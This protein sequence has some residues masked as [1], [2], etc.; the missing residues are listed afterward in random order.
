MTSANKI[1]KLTAVAL[2]P[3]RAP[4]T[5][6]TAEARLLDDATPTSFSIRYEDQI[7]IWKGF[8]TD[9]RVWTIMT[10]TTDVDLP[11]DAIGDQLWFANGG[12]GSAIFEQTFLP[13][14]NSVL[15]KVK[16]FQPSASRTGVMRQLGE[17]D[18]V[19]YTLSIDGEPVY[20]RATT[21]FVAS[22][23]ANAFVD[24]RTVNFSSDVP[25]EW[26][27]LM[28]AVDLVNHG[29][30][31]E[32]FIVGFA[33][34]D[35]LVQD[36]VVKKLVARGLTKVSA[37][38]FLRR[39]ESERLKTYLDPLLRIA[40]GETPLANPDLES[41]LTWMNTTRNNVMHRD[42][43]CTRAEAQRGLAVVCELLR[44]LN[45]LGA[46]FVVPS[47]LPFWTPVESD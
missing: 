40:T 34:L 30:A 35:A 18:V 15:L 37:L 44:A 27:G 42:A 20:C 13:R 41:S 43:A 46:S 4:I 9:A 31:R 2:L 38:K 7:E 6:F 36:F 21:T 45:R 19:A 5:P 28:R 11:D 23:G 26:E 32:G 8:T 29:Y 12:R 10:L 14:I 16:Y 39:I 33:I 17:L 3:F 1:P 25:R 47:I 22:L 24:V